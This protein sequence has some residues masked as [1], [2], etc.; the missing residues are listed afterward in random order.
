MICTSRARVVA[1]HANSQKQQAIQCLTIIAQLKS[2]MFFF[3]FLLFYFFRR[4]IL[5][6][7]KKI[8]FKVDVTWEK[9]NGVTHICVVWARLVSLYTLP[10]HRLVLRVWTFHF[11][12]EWRRNGKKDDEIHSKAL[13]L[14]S[15]RLSQT[16]FQFNDTTPFRGQHL[17]V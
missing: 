6:K 11:I 7:Y 8:N 9:W 5:N 15:S 12:F 1:Q 13:F 14:F 16:K 3:L 4:N 10:F 17:L 2:K